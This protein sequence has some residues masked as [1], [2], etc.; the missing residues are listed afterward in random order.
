[1]QR[2]ENECIAALR[3][4]VHYFPN[5]PFDFSPASTCAFVYAYFLAIRRRQLLEIIGDN[6]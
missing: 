6:L 3:E 2:G 1:M 5:Q 4:Q